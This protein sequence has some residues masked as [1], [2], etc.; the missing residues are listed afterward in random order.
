MDLPVGLGK[1]KR[2][3]GDDVMSEAYWVES[4]KDSLSL[5]DA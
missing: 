3:A 5:V 4:A 2:G 1:R